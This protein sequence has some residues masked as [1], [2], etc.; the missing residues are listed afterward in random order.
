MAA[1]QSMT[2]ITALPFSMIMLF[3]KSRKG[4]NG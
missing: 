4:F 2:L 1:L 3:F